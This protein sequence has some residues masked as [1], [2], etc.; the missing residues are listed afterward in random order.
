MRRGRS[1]R[2]RYRPDRAQVHS[3]QQPSALRGR[4]ALTV[5]AEL[6][7]DGFADEARL[8]AAADEMASWGWHLVYAAL[9]G[10]P[11]ARFDSSKA[12]WAFLA[13][14]PRRTP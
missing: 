4:R 8:L 9:V 10:T 11:Y 3:R 5:C 14:V 7:A 2:D 1:V 12:I 13:S 6:H